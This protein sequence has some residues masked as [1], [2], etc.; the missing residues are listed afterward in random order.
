MI[1]FVKADSMTDVTNAT[2]LMTVEFTKTENHVK[3]TILTLSLL[4][5]QLA[6]VSQMLTLCDSKKSAA[7]YLQHVCM[8]LTAKC[9]LQYRL[10]LAHHVLTHLW[11]WMRHAVC[12]EWPLPWKCLWNLK[13]S[14]LNQ[15]YT[16][17]CRHCQTRILYV[18]LWTRKVV[19]GGAC[20]RP[21][22]QTLCLA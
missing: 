7:Y 22:S 2:K 17:Y 10:L 12:H 16:E 3:F 13:R 15:I 19:C 8:K 4:Q 11:C 21:L 5:H 9:P 20:F 6:R 18:E 1:H 14:I